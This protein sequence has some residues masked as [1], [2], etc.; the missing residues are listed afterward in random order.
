VRSA[1]YEGTV[2]H[3]RYAPVDH[4]FS[5]K[6]VLPFLD[7]EEVEEV[8]ALHP[9]WSAE[10]PNVV[11][12][13]RRDYLPSRPGPLADAVRDI[14]G[15]HLGRR[16]AGPVAMLAHLR[17]WGYVFNPISLF[18]CFG[19]DGSRID[20]L[21]A[22]VTNTPWHERHTYVVGG[23]GRHS[24]AKQLHVSPF[25]GMEMDYTLS[26]REPGE[27][28]SLSMRTTRGGEAL[29]DAGLRLERH[30]AE[31]RSLGAFLWRYPLGSMSVSA[32][33]YRQA[34]SLWRAGAPFVPHPGRSPV[35]PHRLGAAALPRPPVL[36]RSGARESH[37]AGSMEGGEQHRG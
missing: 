6:V 9:L 27:R 15:E 1:L 3:H 2:V 8:A 13:R 22:E 37:R 4:R 14:A 7:L 30:G 26:Y 31:R 24:F 10:R 23:P 34:F 5:Y 32:G 19:P 21:V 17:V 20:A 12:F 25:F 11:S 33:I 16:P 28:L 29:F 35:R 36:H 18:Y